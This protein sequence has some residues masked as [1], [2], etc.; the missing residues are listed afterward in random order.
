MITVQ[1]LNRPLDKAH[2]DRHALPIWADNVV[3]PKQLLK[4]KTGTHSVIEERHLAGKDD[5]ED[6]TE[7]PCEEQAVKA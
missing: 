1:T 6:D 4:R 3:E 2:S 7:R 5:V